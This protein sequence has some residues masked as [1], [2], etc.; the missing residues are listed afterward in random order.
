[1]STENEQ[2]TTEDGQA[3]HLPPLPVTA[4]EEELLDSSIRSMA[5]RFHQE[6]VKVERPRFVCRNEAACVAIDKIVADEMWSLRKMVPE[7]TAEKLFE[8]IGKVSL[9]WGDDTLAV[10]A[11]LIRYWDTMEAMVSFKRK[12]R[13]KYREHCKHT[14]EEALEILRQRGLTRRQ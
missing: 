3:V 5:A 4:A 10:G 13:G 12:F 11:I 8:R 6:G 2:K 1:M 14:K 9:D 7:D